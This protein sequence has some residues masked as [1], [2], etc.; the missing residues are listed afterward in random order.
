MRKI[1]KVRDRFGFETGRFENGR[2][3]NLMNRTFGHWTFC[4]S[5][6]R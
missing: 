4:V 1:D 2:N 3:G 6:E 5:T